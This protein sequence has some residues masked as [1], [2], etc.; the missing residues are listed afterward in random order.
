MKTIKKILIA[1]VISFFGLCN[2][3]ISY[4]RENT[5]SLPE[6]GSQKIVNCDAKCQQDL[7]AYLD[8]YRQKYNI[9]AMSMSISPGLSSEQP[10]FDFYSGT[11]TKNGTTH[12]TSESLF[13]VGSMTKAMVAV[14]MLQ[15]EEAGF[16]KLSDKVSAWLP[17][18]SGSW[19]DTT[20]RQLL[21][22]TSGTYNY[23]DDATFFYNLF[24]DPSYFWCSDAL[25]QLA[26]QHKPTNIYFPAGT[27]W[28]YT[29]TNY[30]LAGL[31]I[32]KATGKTLAEN[33]EKRIFNFSDLDL[34]HTIYHPETIP[35]DLA[36][37]VHGYYED[38]GI[39]HDT[40]ITNQSISWASA[41][42]A[43]ISTT[44][45]Y[46]K[47]IRALFSGKILPVQQFAEMK[48]LV[49]MDDDPKKCIKGAPISLDTNVA[50]YG[51]GIG[52]ARGEG[53]PPGGLWVHDGETIGFRT[54]FY[55]FPQNNFIISI[56]GD[57]R[58]D[59][60]DDDNY[61]DL[62]LKIY[63]YFYPGKGKDILR[64]IPSLEN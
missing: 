23:S 53:Y 36:N 47:F 22:H 39:F 19:G 3:V 27:Y 56:F 51:L 18:Y 55:Y 30:Q 58:N 24:Y 17:E 45:D 50:G 32:E 6:A 29:N 10:I 4:A 38:P 26:Y 49:C 35:V 21:N 13:E 20:I 42:G 48:S 64:S 40:D 14:I 28:H 16:L 52:H 25:S 44:N 12:I 43:V 63:Q 60:R 34:K 15:L 59:Y 5:F 41:A 9:P 61:A 8:Q 33:M 7:Q 1:V 57:V 54:I 31:I 2:S 11:T 62:A 37:M 46:T